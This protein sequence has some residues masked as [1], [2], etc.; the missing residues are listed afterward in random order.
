[1][2]LSL[3][4]FMTAVQEDDVLIVNRLA[5]LSWNTVHTIWLV[6]EF[7]RRRVYYRDLDLGRT[8]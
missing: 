1:M 7:N 3:D 5:W 6:E 8:H 2:H 4:E